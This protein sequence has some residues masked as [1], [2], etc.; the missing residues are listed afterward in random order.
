[1]NDSDLNPYGAGGGVTSKNNDSSTLKVKN[2]SIS[3][4]LQ[5]IDEYGG[6]NTARVKKNP[7]T[8]NN[9]KE[10][11]DYGAF[12]SARAVANKSRNKGLELK[13]QASNVSIS[14]NNS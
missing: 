8:R 3:L 4:Q 10:T 7:K 13:S 14:S 5:P 12:N 2:I 6:Y 9:N 1:M 11:F